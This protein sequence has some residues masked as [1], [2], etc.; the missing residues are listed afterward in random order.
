MGKIKI[1]AIFCEKYY[2]KWGK[3]LNK[4]APTSSYASR[5]QGNLTPCM[6]TDQIQL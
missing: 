4:K 1:F 3:L 5:G 6:G 2:T